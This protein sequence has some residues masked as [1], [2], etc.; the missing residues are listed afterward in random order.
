MFSDI[1]LIFST[2]EIFLSSHVP[3]KCLSWQ[4]F[5]PVYECLS[6]PKSNSVNVCP[7]YPLACSAQNLPIYIHLSLFLPEM[8]KLTALSPVCS[9]SHSS[10]CWFGTQRA[11]GTA[12][13]GWAGRR[14]EPWRWTEGQREAVAAG[15][16]NQPVLARRPRCPSPEGDGSLTWTVIL[17]ETK[18]SRIGRIYW[19]KIWNN[20]SCFN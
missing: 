4:L 20:W 5:H 2:P 13:A 14:S 6:P 12:N 16:K 10:S 17:G 9:K 7:I 11:T 18:D 3:Q 15:A 8:S 1:C 19:W